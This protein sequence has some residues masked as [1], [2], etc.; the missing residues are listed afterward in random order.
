MP[1]ASEQ[2]VLDQLSRGEFKVEVCDMRPASVKVPDHS[3]ASDTKI[4][5]GQI[6]LEAAQEARAPRSR[7]SGKSKLNVTF[8][9]RCPDTPED[10][11]IAHR[12]EVA[13]YKLI[14]ERILATR[15]SPNFVGYVASGRCTITGTGLEPLSCASGQGRKAKA[16]AR[17]TRRRAEQTPVQ[18]TVD[19]LVTHQISKPM[20]FQE[21]NFDEDV[22][23]A[24]R[25]AVYF[26]IMWALLCLQANAIVHNDLHDG[27]ILIE[28]LPRAVT[29][30]FK[31]VQNGGIKYFR[32]STRH[33]AYIFDFDRAYARELGPNTYI[34]INGLGVFAAEN[35]LDFSIDL[36]NVGCRVEFEEPFES[37][38]DPAI[39]TARLRDVAPDA[40][41]QIEVPLRA[42][43]NAGTNLGTGLSYDSD[44]QV[45][46]ARVY[47]DK[48]I[49]LKITRE[50]LAQLVSSTDLEV[51]L[52]DPSTFIDGYFRFITKPGTGVKSKGKSVPAVRLVKHG[53]FKY[54]CNK[55]FRTANPRTPAQAIHSEF[56]QRLVVSESVWARATYKYALE[57]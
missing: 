17:V 38:V 54:P 1:F 55:N 18:E 14:A 42:P 4:A 34:D 15:Q 28:T 10:E 53:G 24:D 29:L 20:T 40:D 49:A 50:Q 26:Q 36:F 31:L 7:Q 32:I 37:D 16:V 43:N 35:R 8:K 52:G 22:T 45:P 44:E 30:T 21:F 6:V 19:L 41:G 39:L 12:Y 2:K 11:L 51:L 3:S 47:L 25:T 46:V 56:F 5:F 27:N 57:L 13:V 23:S 33:I 9:I 48:D